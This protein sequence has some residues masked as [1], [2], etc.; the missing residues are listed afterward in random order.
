[1][2]RVDRLLKTQQYYLNHNNPLNHYNKKN[3]QSQRMY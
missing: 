3:F 1:M 2:K